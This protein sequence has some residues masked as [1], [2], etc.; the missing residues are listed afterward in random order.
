MG[1]AEKISEGY[2]GTEEGI[3]PVDWQVKRLSERCV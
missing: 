2:R 3:L 1:K